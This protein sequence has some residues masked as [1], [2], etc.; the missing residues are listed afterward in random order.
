MYVAGDN[1]LLSSSNDNKMCLYLFTTD[2]SICRHLSLS[3]AIFDT[4]D[5]LLCF[6]KPFFTSKLHQKKIIF[7]LLFYGVFLIPNLLNG[8]DFSLMQ[9]FFFIS[10]LGDC[11]HL[12][13]IVFVSI[14]YRAVV[15]TG[16]HLIYS[17]FLCC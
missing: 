9:T 10:L 4:S 15:Y 1:F 16:A 17:I 8:R 6:F 3:Y 14:H 2:F 5:N 7:S 11:I 12:W 13:I